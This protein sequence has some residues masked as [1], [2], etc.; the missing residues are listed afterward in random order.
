LADDSICN[1]ASKNVLVFWAYFICI[2]KINNF[3]EEIFSIRALSAEKTR[4]ENSKI[5]AFPV[6]LEGNQPER[7]VLF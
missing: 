6:F 2:A 3:L 1:F 7:E 4:F 5:T